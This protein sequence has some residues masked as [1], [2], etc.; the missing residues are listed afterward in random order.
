MPRRES[1]KSLTRRTGQGILD[2][3][4]DGKPKKCRKDGGIATHPTVPCVVQLEE[5]VTK[6]CNDWLTA[7]RIMWDRNNTGMGD[8]AGDGRMFRYGI[9]GGGD[10]IGCMPN[11]RHLEIE[12][13]HGKGGVLSKD[14][15]DRQKECARVNAIY[16]IVHG[17]PEL[18]HFMKGLL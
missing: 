5:D 9:T 2:I 17:L 7:E 6:E 13:K 12:Y 14:Q 4:K 16:L 1:R 15:Q 11:G 3:I 18:K 8:I 10:I